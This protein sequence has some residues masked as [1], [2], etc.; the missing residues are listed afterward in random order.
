MALK[1]AFL[2]EY[3][4]EMG[5]TRRLLERLPEADL[6]WKPHDKSFSLGQLASHIANIPHWLEATCDVAVFDLA[7]LGEDTRPKEPKS[8]A[9]VLKAFDENVKKGRQKID[10]QTDA[11]MLAQWTMK[12]GDLEMMT[13]PRVAVLRSFIMNHMIHH[14]GQL[15][16]YLRLRNVPLPAI[17]GPSADEG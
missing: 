1:D 13:M 10:A 9:D 3:D 11:T 12:R 6:A 16:V 17:Y 2:P 7:S 8:I 15:S 5:T 14:R 4:H